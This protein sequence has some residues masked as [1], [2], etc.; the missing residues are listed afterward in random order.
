MIA[1]RSP[2]SSH[3]SPIGQSIVIP[4]TNRFSEKYQIIICN[5]MDNTITLII[6]HNLP[7]TTTVNIILILEELNN[8]LAKMIMEGT[9]GEHMELFIVEYPRLKNTQH[10]L[11]H[12]KMVIIQEINLQ[13]INLKLY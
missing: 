8:L 2:I 12:R 3:V 11:F 5:I 1:T 4:K 9:K 6:N 10:P 13:M 7:Y